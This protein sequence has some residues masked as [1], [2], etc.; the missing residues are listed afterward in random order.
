MYAFPDLLQKSMTQLPGKQ[1]SSF[2]MVTFSRENEL[3]YYGMKK[4]P[5]ALSS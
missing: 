1:S 2:K 3:G 4:W 5:F